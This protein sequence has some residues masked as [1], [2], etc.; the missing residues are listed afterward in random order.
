MAKFRGGIGI[1]KSGEVFQLAEE[2][3]VRMIMDTVNR[4]ERSGVGES[5]SDYDMICTMDT[6]RSIINARICLANETISMHLNAAMAAI[7]KST[8]DEEEIERRMLAAVKIA[9][10]DA[11]ET[12][13]RL[14]EDCTRI[15]NEMRSKGIGK[16]GYRPEIEFYVAERLINFLQHDLARAASENKTLDPDQN[17]SGL[18]EHIEQYVQRRFAEDGEDSTERKASG[19]CDC[20]ACTFLRRMKRD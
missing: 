17:F 9:S 8:D 16:T 13:R 6:C 20:V 7:L 4:G 19:L 12:E 11:N 14:E 10:S 18:Q 5:L 3:I 15:T 1:T 2:D